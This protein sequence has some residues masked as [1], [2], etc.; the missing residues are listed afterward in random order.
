MILMSKPLKMC[1][2]WALAFMQKTR[3]AAKAAK[4]KRDLKAVKA[5]KEKKK[6]KK[7]SRIVAG[8]A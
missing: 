8:M 5:K 6:R 3:D 4:A 7:D 1:L 2:L